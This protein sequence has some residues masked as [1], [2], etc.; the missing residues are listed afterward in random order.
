MFHSCP[1]YYKMKSTEPHVHGHSYRGSDIGTWSRHQVGHA[2]SPSSPGL[3][4]F[5]SNFIRLFLFFLLFTLTVENSQRERTRR[6]D[7]EEWT[8]RKAWVPSNPFGSLDLFAVLH[9]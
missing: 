3:S 6:L 1:P 2:S 7:A 9:S 4:E 8:G 5:F